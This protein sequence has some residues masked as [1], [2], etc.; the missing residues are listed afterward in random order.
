[1]KLSRRTLLGA[2]L[3]GA[4]GQALS[5]P[6]HARLAMCND[7]FRGWSFPEMLRAVHKAG[8]ESVELAPVTLA[9]DASRLSAAQRSEIRAQMSAEGLGYAGLHNILAA[10][11]GLHATTA[12]AALRRRTWEHLRRLTDL[13]ADFGSPSLLVF[14]SGKQRAADSDTT[15]SDA[16][17]RL[18]EGLAEL[19][20]AAQARGVTI[21]L[22]PLAPQFSN[23]VNTLDAAVAIVKAINSPAVMTMFDTHNTVAEKEPHGDLIRRNAAYVRHVHVNEMDG[24]Y[25]GTGGYNFVPVLQALKDIGYRDRVSVE[26]FDFKAGA[27]KIATESASFLRGLEAQLR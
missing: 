22:E 23:V 2:V 8:F 26:V 19:A 4:A 7:A 14:G 11:E 3:A 10:P 20:P 5:A 25:P 27:V 17:S 6:F 24:R 13:T 15:V 12:D 21:L 16:T 18:R 1:M 9:D